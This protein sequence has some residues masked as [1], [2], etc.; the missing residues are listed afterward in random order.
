MKKKDEKKRP[1]GR[2]EGQSKYYEH[3]VT[4]SPTHRRTQLRLYS[5]LRLNRTT[6]ENT[7]RNWL[8]PKSEIKEFG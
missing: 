2:P 3:F 7:S 6:S 1:R 5:L 8:T 4:T